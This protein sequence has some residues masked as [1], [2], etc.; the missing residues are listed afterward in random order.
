MSQRLNGE[1]DCAHIRRDVIWNSGMMIVTTT[2]MTESM[3]M[4]NGAGFMV[5]IRNMCS[6]MSMM[7]E[8]GIA[9]VNDRGD[10]F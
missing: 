6:M 10:I 5:T 4:N 9:A 8:M 1:G 3:V 2:A 7:R